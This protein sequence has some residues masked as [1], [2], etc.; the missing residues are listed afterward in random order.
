[1]DAQFN[2]NK[3]SRTLYKDKIVHLIV[4][5]DESVNKTHFIWDDE[6]FMEITLKRMNCG[7]FVKHN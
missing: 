5:Y 4:T 1:M 3:C 7:R 6:A 2:C